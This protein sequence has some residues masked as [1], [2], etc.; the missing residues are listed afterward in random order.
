[1]SFYENYAVEK[2]CLDVADVNFECRQEGE[3]QPMIIRGIAAVFN[4]IADLTFFR[5]TIL[6]GA[7]DDVLSDD[8]RGLFN[9]D[10]SKIFARSTAGNLKLEQISRGLQYE[11][12][13]PNT[14]F[15]REL[16]SKISRRDVTQSSFAFSVAEEEFVELDTDKPLRKIKKIAR[17]FDV[18]PVTFPAFVDT[19]VARRSLDQLNS[20]TINFNK[21]KNLR[22]KLDLIGE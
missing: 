19:D 10:P 21:I 2:R 22:R 6:P 16:F 9:H 17:L 15:G 3:G 8:V 11:A 4:S 7:F 18:S 1:M 5:E 20:K 14:E 12:E 13:L